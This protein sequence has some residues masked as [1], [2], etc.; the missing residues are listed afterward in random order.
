VNRNGTPYELLGG[1]AQLRGALAQA[2]F[3]TADWM[4]N[5]PE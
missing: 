2:F 5:Q 3:G 4:R 1:E